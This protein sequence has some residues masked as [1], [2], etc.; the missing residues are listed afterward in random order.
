MVS[1]RG[2]QFISKFWREF[3]HLLRASVSLSSGFHPQSNGQ[4]ERANQDLE[5][6]LRCLVSQNPS[7]WSLQL[8]WVE[9]AH[10]SLPVSAT[11]LSPF[12]CSLGYQS[13]IF[14]SL[15]TEVAV[16]SANAFVLRYYRTFPPVLHRRPL[17]PS[18]ALMEELLKHLTEVSIR[19]QQIMEHMASRQSETEWEL[20][21]LCVTAAQRVPVLDP[22]V[23]ATQLLAPSKAILSITCVHGDTRQVPA[24]RV[25]ISAPHGAWPVEVGIVKDLP[26]PVLLGRDWPGFDHLLAAATQPA[27]PAGN[28]RQRKP[29]RKPHRCPV[30][31]ASDSTRNG[32]S[33]AQTSNLYYDVFQQVSGGGAFAKEQH[34]DD[35]LKHCWT[36]VR[37]IKGKEVRPVPHPIPHFI[38][39]NG[40]LYCVT[41]RRG[42]GGD[43]VGGTAGQD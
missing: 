17:L 7:S 36:Q 20:T 35:R 26:V 34:G 24:R 31:L 16:P 38:V 27:S 22:R 3:F 14:P 42:G 4:T 28:R 40:L 32:E 43:S 23:Q 30:L 37:V 15:E 2:P 19:Q 5:G 13:P 41:Q 39:Q 1:D 8:S 10:N 9:Y 33:P 21:T 11:G 12:E 29:R 6:V 18:P 25:N